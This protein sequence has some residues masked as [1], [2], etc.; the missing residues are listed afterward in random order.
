MIS[1]SLWNYAQS[2]YIG[3]LLEMYGAGTTSL[4]LEFEYFIQIST[5][6]SRPDLPGKEK[7]PGPGI[8][9]LTVCLVFFNYSTLFKERGLLCVR[10]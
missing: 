6:S 10:N 9:K 7:E 4:S 3:G 2:R 8:C 5:N 1:C